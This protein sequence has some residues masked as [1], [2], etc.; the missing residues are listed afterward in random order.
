MNPN[1]RRL[2]LKRSTVRE[3]DS[4]YAKRAAGGGPPVIKPGDSNEPGCTN[5]CASCHF[6]ECD[7]CP[8]TF[9]FDDSCL[10]ECFSNAGWTTCQDLCA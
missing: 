2:R 10:P 4:D 7:T 8:F 5:T 1:H 9:C 6:T 3:L